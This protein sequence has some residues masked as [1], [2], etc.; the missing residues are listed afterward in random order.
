MS[1][2]ELAIKAGQGE[3]EH[4]ERLYIQCEKFLNMQ[5]EKYYKLHENL[6][7]SRGVE[8]DDLKVCT[9]FA[10]R[11]AVQ[12]Y[13][14]SDK[15]YKFITYLTF[16]LRNVFNSTAGVRTKHSRNEPLNSCRSFDESLPGA[17]DELTFGDTL[18]DDSTE[19]ASDIETR[20]TLEGVFPLVKQILGPGKARLYN[21]LVS[22]YCEDKTISE[23]AEAEGKNINALFQD[24]QRAYRLL[25]RNPKLQI[26]A[27]DIIGS[28]YHLSGYNTYKNTGKSCVEWAVEKLDSK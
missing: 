5:A 1:N 19:T 24:L 6:C 3:A 27:G 14:E 16:P 7:Q 12:A 21:I 9:F 23:I 22:R 26:Y 11:E 4:M 2:E 18:A 13:C 8:V 20:A 28:T 15:Q 25:K 17:D 10:L